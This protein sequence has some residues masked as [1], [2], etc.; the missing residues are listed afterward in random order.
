MIDSFARDRRVVVTGLGI[1]APNGVGKDA[2]WQSLMESRSGID[3]ITLFDP[4]ELKT[5]FAGE[6]K[7]YEFSRYVPGNYNPKRDS[8]SSRFAITATAMA[9]ED[10]GLSL[11]E[12]AQIDPLV[13]AIGISTNPMDKIEQ[14]VLDVYNKG[15]RFANPF[16]AKDSFPQAVSNRVTSALGIQAEA[17]T[18]ST[19]CPA[20]LTAIHQAAALIKKGKFDI[21]IAGGSDSG[22]T[23]STMAAFS[24]VRTLSENNGNPKTA[25]RP[26]DKDNDGGVMAEGAAMFII[27]E[28]EHALNRGATPYMEI[29]GYGSKNDSVGGT[30]GDG[31]VDSMKLALDNSGL[32]PNRITYINAHGPSDKQLEQEEINAIKSCF[33]DHANRIK[34]SSIKGVTGNALAAAGAMQF[35]SCAL[36]MRNN[37][38]PPTANF[39]TP[40]AN[41][42]LDG[43]T[44]Q[45]M[46]GPI[47][48][49]LINIHG[50]GGVNSSM[51][52]KE[53]TA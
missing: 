21:G 18:I 53:Y 42:M 45:P 36:S 30:N 23:F 7:E 2:F 46:H 26:F 38:I 1:V 27:E 15:A 4:S 3:T 6:V 17:I 28:L 44:D 51:V 50:Y 25:S 8:R 11:H 29:L 34:V 14:Q 12:L 32:P 33:G 9:I 47:P 41:A 5:R 19:G 22:I 43:I 52:V 24:S 48:Y 31:F 13:L 40:H 10:A 49:A 16:T 20:G 37:V 35:A 39:K